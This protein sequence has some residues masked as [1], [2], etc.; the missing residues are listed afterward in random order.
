[1]NFEKA[2]SSYSH[3]VTIQ[4]V[5]R[6]PDFT[7]RDFVIHSPIKTHF[8]EFFKSIKQK[9]ETQVN[10]SKRRDIVK[11]LLGV[12]VIFEKT[13]GESMSM[14]YNPKFYPLLAANQFR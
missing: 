2:L 8:N 1:M 4:E 7:T 14:Y 6:S 13:D 10:S 5:T 12:K 11:V 9:V 3:D